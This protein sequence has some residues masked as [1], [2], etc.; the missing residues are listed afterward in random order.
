M[1]IHIFSGRWPEP[2]VGPNHTEPGGTLIPVTEAERREVF[3]RA[4]GD[5]HLLMDLIL[6]CI[7][8]HPKARAHASEI[9]ERLAEM[10]LQFPASFANLLEML[11]QFESITKEN[12]D[13]RKVNR[14]VE[15]LDKENRD[16]RKEMSNLQN[17]NGDLQ[18]QMREEMERII[19]EMQKEMERIVSEAWELKIKN[20]M[21]KIENK[22]AE[23]RLNVHDLSFSQVSCYLYYSKIWQ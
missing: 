5:D 7:K 13:L 2:Q 16:L 11:K 19:S 22:P 12:R 8:N 10:V 3:L 15:T 9:V 18:K 23:W 4:I 1:L 20:D 6:K 21:L 17:E 14:Q